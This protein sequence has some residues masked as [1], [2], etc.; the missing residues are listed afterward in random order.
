MQEFTQPSNSGHKIYLQEATVS[1]AIQFSDVLDT[2]SESVTTRFLN[3]V[4]HPEHFSDSK[5]WTEGDRITALI[6]YYVHTSS[7]MNISLSYDCEYCNKRHTNN[8]DI[9]GLAKECQ[10]LNGKGYREHK[11]KDKTIVFYPITGEGLEAVQ[12]I[13]IQSK[14]HESMDTQ[15][16]MT[17]ERVIRSFD[18]ANRKLSIAERR[19]WI[20]TLSVSDYRVFYQ[21]Y[22]S[23]QASM[24]HGVP[25]NH[26]GGVACLP[27]PSHPCI[28]QYLLSEETQG[29]ASTRLHWPFLC[30]FFIPSIS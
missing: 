11:F 14:Q 26:I 8:F 18:F 30:S 13:R 9:R 25:Y 28:N 20:N 29:G 27:A 24:N 7:D 1:Q 6:W 2:H 15:R 3:T 22:F 5:D 21:E 12:N 16:K 23:A 19:D 10:S 17:I 4:Q